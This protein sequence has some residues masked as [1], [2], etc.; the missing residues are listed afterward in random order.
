MQLGGR[1]LRQLHR[2]GRQTELTDLDGSLTGLV[3]GSAANP[4]PT[5][6]V[7]NDPAGNNFFNAPVITPECQ[8]NVPGLTA[9]VNT[10]PYEY[11]TTAIYPAC[12]PLMANGAN[13]CGDTVWS[14]SCST[15]A[16]GGVPLY[17][18]YVTDA[19][20][21]TYTANKTGYTS[22]HPSIRMMGQ[23][24]GQRS[25]LTM[26]HVS[27]YIDTTIPAGLQPSNP[28]VFVAGQIYYFYVLYASPSLHQIYSMYV[29][30]G[31]R[32]AMLPV[33]SRPA[34]SIPMT[35]TWSPSS[36]A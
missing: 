23:D 20:M 17:R 33:R 31:Y 24:T 6:S 15:Q 13:G 10:S 12:T 4:S 21:Q 19:E 34:S 7:N 5:I 14:A 18:Q 2:C 1:R 9:T 32:A 27:Y 36:P 26:N 11:V 16:C 25:S 35:G 22:S 28:N 8:S 29:G 3:E 30:T